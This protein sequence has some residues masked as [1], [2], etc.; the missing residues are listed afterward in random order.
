M[1]SSA[2]IP[3]ASLLWSRSWF[4]S[5]SLPIPRTEF[6]AAFIASRQHPNKSHTCRVFGRCFYRLYSSGS[7]GCR[8]IRIPLQIE[9]RHKNSGH[10]LYFTCLSPIFMVYWI[11]Y[12]SRLDMVFSVAP[13]ILLMLVDVYH[14]HSLI[15]MRKEF[16]KMWLL[17]TT[18]TYF[19]I[20]TRILG[21]SEEV[22]CGHINTQ[23]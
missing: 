23:T 11:C 17:Y 4:T 15:L 21:N 12:T 3:A 20:I 19:R 18:R 22:A 14:D 13:T 7:V 9:F 16:C 6:T 2:R 1:F 10:F 8:D 5:S